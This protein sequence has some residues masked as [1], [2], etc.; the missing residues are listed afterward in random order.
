M[1]GNRWVG[2]SIPVS[3]ALIALI[4]LSN[5]ARAS[6]WIEVLL[7]ADTGAPTAEEVVEWAARGS[8]DAPPLASL[9]VAPFERVEFLIPEAARARGDF[10]E[11]LDRY[12]ES[13][14]AR[15]QRFIVVEYP[16]TI[17]SDYVLAAFRADRHVLAAAVMETSAEP[18]SRTNMPRVVP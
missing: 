8:P 5:A 13:P 16:D 6:T 14:A 18:V 12:P 2:S 9:E 7:S 3:F 1:I 4:G 11:L 15:L 17:E 10:K